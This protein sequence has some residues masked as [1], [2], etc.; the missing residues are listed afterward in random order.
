M[1]LFSIWS[2][3]RG[4]H[5]E[6][7]L[8]SRFGSGPKIVW[9]ERPQASRRKI[10]AIYFISAPKPSPDDNNPWTL[11]I[12][13]WFKLVTARWKARALSLSNSC[14]LPQIASWASTIEASSPVVTLKISYPKSLVFVGLKVGG[15]Y[16][17]KCPRAKMWELR[18]QY[19]LERLE[20]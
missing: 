10:L 4:F 18:I 13:A 11:L 8:Q 7:P 12:S 5:L 16:Q 15:L 19:K 17:G 20:R 3:C 1:G 14:G 6:S 2:L 9:T